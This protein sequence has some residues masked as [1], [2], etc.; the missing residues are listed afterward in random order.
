MF[1]RGHYPDPAALGNE[2][3]LMP[4]ER[5]AKR[6]AGLEEEEESQAGRWSL[7]LS[8]CSRCSSGVGWALRWAPELKF[9]QGESWGSRDAL[10]RR[11]ILLFNKHA[12]HQ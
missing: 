7:W 12:K 2:Q 10:V 5:G 3:V 11:L 4:V 1:I 8:L 6:K 9:S